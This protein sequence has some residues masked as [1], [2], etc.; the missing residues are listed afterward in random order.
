MGSAGVHRRRANAGLGWETLT[1]EGTTFEYVYDFGDNWQHRLMVEKILAAVPGAT[2]PA[3]IAGRRAC[4]P[5]DCGGVWGYTDLLTAISDPP[6]PEHDSML[7]WVGGVY[8]PGELDPSE[9]AHRLR[10]GR[11]VE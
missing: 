7:E 6:H 10:L 11:L 3:C 8:D 2:Y 5:E 1:E 4:P 9:F